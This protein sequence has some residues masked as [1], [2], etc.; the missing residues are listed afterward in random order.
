M[1]KIRK[2]IEEEVARQK[3]KGPREENSQVEFSTQQ[4][5]W[6]K[7]KDQI[8]DH[9]IKL[10]RYNKKER[11]RERERDE[12]ERERERERGEERFTTLSIRN[13]IVCQRMF[14]LRWLIGF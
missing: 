8:K 3:S 11:E 5:I 7:G 13:I 12:R 2:E 4:E 1:Y 9:E 10:E 14:L 6:Q